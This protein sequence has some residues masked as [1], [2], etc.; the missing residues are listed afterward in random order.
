MDL[1]YGTG[2]VRERVGQFA[3]TEHRCR[4]AGAECCEFVAEEAA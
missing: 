1:V 4:A 2:S 3:A